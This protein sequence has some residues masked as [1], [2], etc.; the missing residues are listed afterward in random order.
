MDFPIRTGFDLVDSDDQVSDQERDFMRVVVSIMKILC[1][2][3]MKSA[4][5]YCTA[6]GRNVVTGDDMVKAL[7]YE[8]HVF[9]DKDITERFVQNL[10]EEKGHTYDTTDEDE[11]EEDE[12]E[13]ENQEDEIA[14]THE[15]SLAD[16]CFC[17]AVHRIEASWDQWCPTDPVKQMLKRAINASAE[18]HMTLDS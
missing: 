7:K 4:G 11:S 3:S 8:S 1:E 12:S 13:E 17:N 10:E 15:V 6:C 2:E 5:R 14:A 18:K 16:E 9:W